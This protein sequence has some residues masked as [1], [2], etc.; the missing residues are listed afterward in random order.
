[1][2]YCV[3]GRQPKSVLEKA[4][5][6]KV[7][8]ID[9]ERLIDYLEDYPDKEFILTVP[10]GIWEELEWELYKAFPNII[11]CLEDLSLVKKCQ[12]YGIRFYWAY[13]CYTFYDL[14]G[15]TALKPSHIS[16]GAPL[17]FDLEKVS[18]MT[19]IDLRLCP[20]LAYDTYIPHENGLF[21][22]W[23]R[24]EDV[25]YYEKYVAVLDFETRDLKKE[26]ALL[27]V[28]QED[29]NWPGNLNIL[30]PNYGLNIDNRSIDENIG[31]IRMTCGQRCMENGDCHICETC[32][33]L[34]NTIRDLHYESED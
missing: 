15:I 20:T 24:P 27:Q 12:E 30:I 11:L 22:T 5:Q 29:K 1:M 31:K 32:F 14:Q 4:D 9:R 28:Y 34:G 16:L 17:S 8:Y 10:K 3:N 6:I 19:D 18:K 33:T 2:K 13:P 25:E 7:Q 26:I 21:G 23:I